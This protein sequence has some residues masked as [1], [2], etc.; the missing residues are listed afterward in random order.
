MQ[1]ERIPFSD[2]DEV[3]LFWYEPTD[4]FPTTHVFG[5]WEAGVAS[6][7]CAGISLLFLNNSVND[8]TTVFS[9]L[10]FGANNPPDGEDE[11]LYAGRYVDAFTTGLREVQAR[12][13]GRM[14]R[15]ASGDEVR[16]L[17]GELDEHV[18]WATPGIEI[19][20]AG[21]EGYGT[22]ADYL[23]DDE[24]QQLL[25][26]ILWLYVEDPDWQDIHGPAPAVVR[27]RVLG[28][29]ALELPGDQDLVALAINLYNKGAYEEVSIED[30]E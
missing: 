22:M 5:R 29:T 9:T 12:N 14:L 6:G 18:S 23:A 24:N 17:L 15:G 1:I 20:S 16:A 4:V 10:R 3:S 25:L 28:K 27:I 11:V 26:A 21:I 7:P 30:E 2:D 13:G 19:T 8:F